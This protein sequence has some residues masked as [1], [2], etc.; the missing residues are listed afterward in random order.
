MSTVYCTGTES[1][2][3]ALSRPICYREERFNIA[4][5]TGISCTKV[6]P[7]KLAGEWEMK[8]TN[9]LVRILSSCDRKDD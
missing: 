2:A 9:R 3:V 7:L 6:L 8:R 5:P 4:E 1:T